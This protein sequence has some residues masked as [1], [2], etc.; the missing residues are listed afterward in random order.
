MV[1]KNFSDGRIF[2]V[3]FGRMIIC[4]LLLFSILCV[5]IKTKRVH[6]TGQI[7][8]KDIF[9][10][11]ELTALP[12]KLCYVWVSTRDVVLRKYNLPCNNRH[13]Y[14]LDLQNQSQDLAHSYYGEISQQILDQ[15]RR[16]PIFI[17]TEIT[18]Q[19]FAVI[20]KM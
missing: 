6:Y 12:E 18:N 15:T 2:L 3:N 1:S 20:I 11:S 5:S 19:F 8:S 4:I 10:S 17:L 9:I 16:V 7:L 13:R 14:G